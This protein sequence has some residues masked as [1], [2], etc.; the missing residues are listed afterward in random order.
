MKKLRN[1]ILKRSML[2]ILACAAFVLVNAGGRKVYAGDE[3][4]FS[5]QF[6]KEKEPEE[7]GGEIYRQWDEYSDCDFDD[8]EGISFDEKTSTL[9]M[10]NFSGYSEFLIW[11]DENE[12]LP[13]NRLLTIDVKGNNTIYGLKKVAIHTL[14]NGVSV[15]FVGDGVINFVGED[16]EFTAVWI[17]G[18]VI[19]DGP[20]V[21][22]IHRKNQYCSSCLEC[23]NLEVLSGNLN[24]DTDCGAMGVYGDARLKGGN[25][26]IKYTYDEKES[27]WNRC[28]DE[29]L[30][31]VNK[32]YI[33]G[34]TVTFDVDTYRESIIGE[35]D[36]YYWLDKSNLYMTSGSLYIN[37]KPEVIKK[38]NKITLKYNDFIDA[39]TCNISGGNIYV[40]YESPKD[41]TDW[42]SVIMDHRFF[43]AE[44]FDVANAT[45]TIT[46][47][48]RILQIMSDQ[49]ADLYDKNVVKF[50]ETKEEE[51]EKPAIAKP[52]EV[53]GPKAGT[54]I[55]DGKYAYI[56]T[57]PST[58]KYTHA[59]G[60]PY[61]LKKNVIKGEV[62]VIKLVDTKIES[63]N[64][65]YNVIIDEFKYDIV[66]IAPA[67]FANN[68]KIKKVVIGNNVKNIGKRAFFNCSKLNTVKINSRVISTIGDQAFYRVKGVM[69]TFTV[70]GLVKPK[71]VILLNKARTNSYIVA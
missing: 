26:N 38:S 11:C 50:E 60:D 63:V 13:N 62:E 70:P 14:V 37:A 10:N 16:Y 31:D 28:L 65:S 69:I 30:V 19:I 56:V 58:I 34:A 6:L 2:F 64:I 66:S 55:S 21:N 42:N 4:N 45:F 71:Y 44:T 36:S 15:K 67:A 57:K 7:Y 35:A 20:T 43:E 22:I 61:T 9:E 24:I 51:P 53:N 27:G 12:E 5:F 46:G 49:L 18:D 8:I 25:V 47:K 17:S 41:L 23:E 54:T 59:D 40:N 29:S 39:N 32:L 3:A 48:F 68:T 52:Y 33:E 1:K